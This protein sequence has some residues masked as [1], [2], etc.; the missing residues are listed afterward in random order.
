MCARSD[1]LIRYI[2][3]GQNHNYLTAIHVLLVATTR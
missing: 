1:L 3:Y 2:V